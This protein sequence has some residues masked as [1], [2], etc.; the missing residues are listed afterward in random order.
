MGNIISL[1]RSWQERRTLL[2]DLKREQGDRDESLRFHIKD[3]LT[4]ASRGLAIGDHRYAES[5][6]IKLMLE[7]PQVTRESPLA[8]PVLLG[9]R[10][11]T[12]AQELM[13]AGQKRHP[14]DPQ[15]A[16][17]F[18]EVAHAE[19]DF[20]TAAARWALVRKRFPGVVEGYT[21]GADAHAEVGELDQADALAEAALKRFPENIGGFLGYARIAVLRKDWTE[22]LVRWQTVYDKFG[23]SSGCMGIAQALTRLSRFDDADEVLQQAR[24]R[25]GTDPGPFAES[26]RVAE[27]RGDIPEAI[28]RW[29]ALLY[30]FPLDMHVSLTAAEAFARFNALSEAEAT[31]RAAIDRHPTESRPFIEL[32]RLLHVKQQDYAAAAEAWTVVRS[33]FPDLEEAYLRGAEALRYADQAQ[34]AEAL[35]REHREKFQ[36]G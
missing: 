21:W 14:N 8:L 28:T 20:S 29:N 17:G 13:L 7:S 22:A 19:R 10:R 35:H 5:V 11:F 30:R 26:A 9:L 23:H 32:A 3:Q 31:L 24:Y 16:K 12:E 2:R 36:A 27:A 25:F 4:Y 33:S 6:W 15:Y 34:Q 18:A 1:L